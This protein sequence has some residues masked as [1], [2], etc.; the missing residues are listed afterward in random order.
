MGVS[1]S[2]ASCWHACTCAMSMCAPEPAYK[3]AAG[4]QI[5]G[6]PPSER[7]RD[8]R[9]RPR[10][11]PKCSPAGDIAIRPQFRRQVQTGAFIRQ[12]RSGTARASVPCAQVG[13]WH[14]RG[15]RAKVSHANQIV[16]VITSIFST[17]EATVAT[18]I[19]RNSLLSPA[20][21]TPLKLHPALASRNAAS[22][23]AAI[24]YPPATVKIRQI[25][26]RPHGNLAQPVIWS[27]PLAKTPLDEICTIG[28]RSTSS[29]CVLWLWW[30]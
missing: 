19:Y 13:R 5:T 17:L 30:R 24:L 28:A 22:L 23:P 2:R 18:R 12:P 27:V 25:S 1:I 7:P 14:V 11:A 9:D 15:R 8:S 4:V 16:A 29:S 3:D 26:F 20:V 10:T 21:K 6:Q